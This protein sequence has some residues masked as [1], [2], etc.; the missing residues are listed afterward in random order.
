MFHFTSKIGGHIAAINNNV[1]KAKDEID[2]ALLKDKCFN[3][4]LLNCDNPA[5]QSCAT[6]YKCMSD[7]YSTH[8]L[9][10]WTVRTLKAK[11]WRYVKRWLTYVT[12]N[13]N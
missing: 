11:H 13:A 4:Y 8:T 2:N 1:Q 12:Y 9:G 7:V 10:G 3:K 5:V 6:V